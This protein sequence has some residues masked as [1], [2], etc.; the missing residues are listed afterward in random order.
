MDDARKNGTVVG[1]K[2]KMKERV[3]WRRICDSSLLPSPTTTGM[4]KWDE[5]MYVLKM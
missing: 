3:R 2:V 5:G 4:A 1:V